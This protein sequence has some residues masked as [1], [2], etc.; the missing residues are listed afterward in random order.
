MTAICLTKFLIMS[1]ITSLKVCVPLMTWLKACSTNPETLCAIASV[2]RFTRSAAAI[3]ALMSSSSTMS[4][5][6]S[7][8]TMLSVAG[9][10]TVV[11]VAAAAPAPPPTLGSKSVNPPSVLIDC[12]TPSLLNSWIGSRCSSSSMAVRIFS[13][14]FFPNSTARSAALLNASPT[15]S[16]M[17]AKSPVKIALIMAPKS[18][19]LSMTVLTA[20][21]KKSK[22]VWTVPLIAPII[23]RTIALSL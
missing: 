23:P 17:A 10:G 16:G 11:V 18:L 2:C 3:I 15:N 4:S 9:T 22:T 5:S 8:S 6:I 1:C 7:M 21:T 20:K 12:A 13:P 19:T 14:A